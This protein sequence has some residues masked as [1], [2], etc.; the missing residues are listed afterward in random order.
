MYVIR[1][2]SPSLPKEQKYR[3][4]TKSKSPGLMC[5][6][7]T[8]SEIHSELPPPLTSCSPVAPRADLPH[9]ELSLPPGLLL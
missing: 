6:P 9:R 5:G 3:K 4:K 8:R 2:A 7:W 1:R